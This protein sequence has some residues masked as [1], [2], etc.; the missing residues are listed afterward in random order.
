MSLRISSTWDWLRPRQDWTLFSSRLVAE[1]SSAERDLVRGHFGINRDKV[2]VS[3]LIIFTLLREK[4]EVK[5]ISNM[6]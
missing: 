6:L 1:F 4:V 3:F 2:S 5:R